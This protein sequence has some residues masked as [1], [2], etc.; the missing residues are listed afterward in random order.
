[1]S[2]D[3]RPIGAANLPDAAR[4][5]LAGASLSDRPRGFTREVE[6]E[7]QRCKLS[8][9]RPAMAAGAAA[10][11]AYRS[12]M[13]VGYVEAHPVEKAPDPVDGTGVHVLHCLRVP[14]AAERG[15]VEPALLDALAAKAT[16][17]VAV[18]AREKAWGALGFREMER[19]AAEVH[20]SE[21]VLWFRGPEGVVP[22]TVPVQRNLPRPPGKARVDLFT[23]D[24]CPWDRYVFDLVRGVCGTMK[25]EVA[26]FETDCN[27]RREVLRTGVVSA[28][29]INGTFQPWVRPWRLPDE[30]MI[31]RTL[32]NSY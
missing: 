11:A 27:R 31:R 20:S 17:G 24:R 25:A 13:L 8:M 14:E 12:G 19:G 21:R 10:F 4:L 3:I 32:E 22:R 5:C 16:G 2:L 6:T 18:L 15:E 30:H 26:L 28:V 1:M 7:A 23:S 9:L 29:A